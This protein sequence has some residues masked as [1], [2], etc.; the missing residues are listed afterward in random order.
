M[1]KS[2]PKSALA[3]IYYHDDP[4]GHVSEKIIREMVNQHYNGKDKNPFLDEY[5]VTHIISR[6]SQYTDTFTELQDGS[7]KYFNNIILFFVDLSFTPKTLDK[8]E[9]AIEMPG[10]RQ[11]VWIDHHDSSEALVNNFDFHKYPNLNRYSTILYSKD[12]C[13]AVLCAYYAQVIRYA[14]NHKKQIW[15]N[16][17]PIDYPIVKNGQLNIDIDDH[18]KTIYINYNVVLPETD[19]GLVLNQ[20]QF[21]SDKFLYHLDAYDRHT[22]NDPDADAFMFGF[23]I[24]E[25]QDAIEDNYNFEWCSISKMSSMPYGYHDDETLKNFESSYIAGFEQNNDLAEAVIIPNGIAAMDYQNYEYE[26]QLKK[27]KIYNVF[28]Y[29]IIVKNAMGNSMNFC[30]ILDGYLD[31]YKGFNI[32]D[33]VHIGLIGHYDMQTDKYTY[34][35]YENFEHTVA[36][37]K[38]AEG[39]GGGGHPGAAGF[40]LDVNILPFFNMPPTPQPESSSIRFSNYFEEWIFK[41]YPTIYSYLIEHSPNKTVRYST[42]TVTV[43]PNEN[44][45]LTYKNDEKDKE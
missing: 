21:A 10:V 43:V 15:F 16:M 35:I 23:K 13:G 7:D 18:S 40:S 26:Y 28:G 37:N 4:D 14:G 45:I 1:M 11:V 6:P 12:A 39:F 31:G 27:V 8:L 3:C 36:V 41:Y 30:G 19:K 20:F 25:Y 44:G 29:N 38:I 42:P 5:N 9:E 32:V 24:A 2:N 17:K 33:K 34:S 22:R